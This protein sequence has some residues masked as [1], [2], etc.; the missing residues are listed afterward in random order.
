MLGGARGIV[1]GPDG[2]VSEGAR[3]AG[4][5][6][7]GAEVAG[8]GGGLGAMASCGPVAGICSW[9]PEGGPLVWD[10]LNL[11]PGG[12][13]GSCGWDGLGV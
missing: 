13:G 6:A 8:G 3:D 11:G 4:G 9:C 1:A 10:W 7:E 2:G 5:L 12:A